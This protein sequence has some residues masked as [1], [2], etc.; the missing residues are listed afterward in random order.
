MASGSSTFNPDKPAIVIDSGSGLVKAGFAGDDNPKCIFQTV[1]GKPVL[2][3]AAMGGAG[4][5][6]G[7][8]VGPQ[9]LA[10]RGMLQLNYPV[11]HGVVKNWDDMEAIWAHTFDNELRVDPTDRGVL[12]TE[13]PRNPRANREKMAEIMF[14]TFGIPALYVSIQ[15]V[16]SL[17]SSGLTTGLV[18]ESGDGVTHVV[19]IFEG[20]S[21]DHAI[22]RVNLAG[23]DV[24]QYL[25][26]LLTE[27]GAVMTSSSEQ[28]L[29]RELKEK[30][31]YVSMDFA[32]D[33]TKS[34]REFEQ[35]F[36]MPDGRSITAGSER[37]RAPE[38][39]FQPSFLGQDMGGL[40]HLMYKCVQACDLDL[41][42]P[43]W[44]NIVLGG[45]NTMFKNF[46]DRL[47]KELGTLVTDPGA[48]LAIKDV[49]NRLHSVWHGGSIVAALDSFRERWATKEQYEEHG[50]A[51]MHR[52]MV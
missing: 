31:C 19:P 38:V 7:T 9:A 34:E 25:G 8:F 28:E 23:R 49:P 40:Q 52:L 36:P 6:R 46:D 35:Q 51:V 39:L 42:R 17:Y 50:S 16:L 14:E 26:S 21:L 4:G 37:F 44:N 13:A 41:R 43:L 45:G 30:A 32:G 2:A 33:M 12:L 11:E 22:Q 15:A 18:V 3:Q 5:K 27:H 1:T 47:V 24:S 48:K 29:V 10:K 20:Y